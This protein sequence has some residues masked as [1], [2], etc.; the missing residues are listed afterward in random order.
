MPPANHFLATLAQPPATEG[1]SRAI[2]ALVDGLPVEPDKHADRHGVTRLYNW[3]SPSAIQEVVERTLTVR[4]L[5]DVAEQL[6]TERPLTSLYVMTCISEYRATQ[7]IERYTHRVLGLFLDRPVTG[8]EIDS[9]QRYV[10]CALNRYMFRPLADDSTDLCYLLA[11]TGESIEALSAAGKDILLSLREQQTGLLGIF[12]LVCGNDMIGHL[13]PMAEA[14]QRMLESG[15]ISAEHA[16]RRVT[17]GNQFFQGL[18]ESCQNV[19]GNSRSVLLNAV[20]L[21]D[22]QPNASTRITSLGSRYDS[23][24]YR[25]D[26]ALRGLSNK[27]LPKFIDLEPFLTQGQELPDFENLADKVSLLMAKL[28]T[29]ED[30]PNGRQAACSNLLMAVANATVLRDLPQAKV[31]ACLQEIAPYASLQAAHELA[32]PNAKRVL[33]DFIIRH[34]LDQ[35]SFLSLDDRKHQ[36]I[37]DLGI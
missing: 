14:P 11:I 3:L 4:F 8:A 31:D 19:L 28:R 32:S 7:D 37:Q 1:V 27:S 6:L 21:M 34:H 35:A 30:N 36:L 33:T 10:K 20:R 2:L 18:Q 15:E 16:I 26:L 24:A 13:R 22:D 12:E 29:V 23:P 9:I 5:E 25:I 17:L